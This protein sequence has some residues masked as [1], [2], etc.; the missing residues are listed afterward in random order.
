[1]DGRRSRRL[2]LAAAGVAL[3]LRLAFA[4]FY[5]TD[6]PLTHDERE[7]LSLAESLSGGRG[8]TYDETGDTGTARGL[9][10]RLGIPPSLHCSQ[11][12]PDRSLLPRS[13][14]SFSRRSV[15]SASC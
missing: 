6:K 12:R 11:Y 2:I 4:F 15:Q 14:R 7:Y 13:S 3:L 5:W 10:G 9:A 1:M 8:F